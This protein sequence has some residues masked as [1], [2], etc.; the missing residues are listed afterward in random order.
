[1]NALI[2]TK[3]SEI[4]KVLINWFE[5]FSKL[6]IKLT[7]L[8]RLSGHD[9]DPY[10]VFVNILKEFNL[11]LMTTLR[12]RRFCNWAR[13]KFFLLWKQKNSAWPLCP[14]F[15]L[16]FDGAWSWLA[17]FPNQRI[18]FWFFNVWCKLNSAHVKRS[19]LWEKFS[20]TLFSPI[21]IYNVCVVVFCY[22]ACTFQL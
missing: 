5:K 20:N 21:N 19:L 12:I 18:N 8:H 4:E 11:V 6:A 14:N 16:L 1:M 9:T 17:K 22:S 13:F 15:P 2:I 7:Y 3:Y 10:N